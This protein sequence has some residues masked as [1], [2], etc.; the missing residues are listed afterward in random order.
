MT[1]FTFLSLFFFLQI[2]LLSN[3]LKLTKI[4]KDYLKNKEVLNLCVDPD[5]MP[6]EMIDNGIIGDLPT[7]CYSHIEKELKK[8]FPKGKIINKEN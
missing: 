1:K 7:Y 4:E 2:S 8:I 5:W 6:Y 3:E